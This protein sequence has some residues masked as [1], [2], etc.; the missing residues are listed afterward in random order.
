M[1]M[2][3]DSTIQ[4]RQ[5]ITWREIDTDLCGVHSLCVDAFVRFEWVDHQ[6]CHVG[7]ILKHAAMLS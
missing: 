5:R 7:V 6:Q 4:S 2:G 3:R 1:Y